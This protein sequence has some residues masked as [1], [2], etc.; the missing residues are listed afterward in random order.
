MGLYVFEKK[1]GRD[2]PVKAKLSQPNLINL[3]FYVVK[4]GSG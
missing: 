3:C 2:F 4:K 1:E